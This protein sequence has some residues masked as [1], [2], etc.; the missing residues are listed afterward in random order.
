MYISP[1]KARI[2]S[3]VV[4]FTYKN[5][6][7]SFHYVRW[8]VINGIVA[9]AKLVMLLVMSLVIGSAKTY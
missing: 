1:N 8:S 5:L 6:I 2:S 9:F 7:E 3:Q 4:R